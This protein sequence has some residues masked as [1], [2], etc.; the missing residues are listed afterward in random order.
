MKVSFTF[1]FIPF[2]LFSTE[3]FARADKLTNKDLALIAKKSYHYFFP[4]VLMDI[5][6]KTQEKMLKLKII[7][8]CT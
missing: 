7:S 1:L 3:L 5:T 8:F 4:A 2:F 6:R